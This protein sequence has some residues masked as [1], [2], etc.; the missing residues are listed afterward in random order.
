MKKAF[1]KSLNSQKTVYRYIRRKGWKR[2]L[3]EN[4]LESE[5]SIETKAKSIALGTFIGLSPFWGLHTLLALWL[6]VSFRLN[7]MLTFL[8]AQLSI[9]PLIP[10]FVYLALL[11]GSPFVKNTTSPTRQENFDFQSL[12]NN[13]LQ[14]LI[15]STLMAISGAVLFGVCSYLLMKKFQKKTP[16]VKKT[17]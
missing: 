2:F 17:S 4:I 7:K 16:P 5:G 10:F 15:G 8:F 6:S 12:Q 14:Y 11:I 3:K 9:A 13:L 1:Q